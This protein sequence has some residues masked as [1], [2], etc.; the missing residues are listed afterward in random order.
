MW[1]IEHLSKER[2]HSRE[3]ENNSIG[4]PPPSQLKYTY[5]LHSHIMVQCASPLLKDTP[6]KSTVL[7][8]LLH[9]CD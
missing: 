4:V 1:G 8:N 3:E 6:H 9:P 2:Y 5:I 7:T